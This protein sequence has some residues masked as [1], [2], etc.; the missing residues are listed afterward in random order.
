MEPGIILGIAERFDKLGVVGAIIATMLF[1]VVL[2][3]FALWRLWSF[4]TDQRKEFDGMF[5][6][7]LIAINARLA[8]IEVA[9]KR[10][11]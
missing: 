6:R 7:H 9:A 5:E 8:Q 11:G 2:H 3:A 1:C 4:A 10:D